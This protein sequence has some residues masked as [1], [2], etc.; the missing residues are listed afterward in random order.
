MGAD[1]F[2]QGAVANAMIRVDQLKSCSTCEG[3]A[4]QLNA[5]HRLRIPP[6]EQFRGGA[7]V[8][9]CSIAARSWC[10]Y[11]PRCWPAAARSRWYRW[12]VC[13]DAP[14]RPPASRRS[15]D[16]QVRQAVSIVA[17]VAALL[18]AVLSSAAPELQAEDTP[19]LKAKS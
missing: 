15:L 3:G 13:R 9:P 17:A 14:S 5:F 16:H 10:P 8:E 7:S 11:W 1:V 18:L 4:Q 2:G 12:K 6:L 19:A